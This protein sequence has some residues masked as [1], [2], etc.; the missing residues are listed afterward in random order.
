MEDKVDQLDGEAALRCE[1]FFCISR[2]IKSIALAL[3]F[4]LESELYTTMFTLFPYFHNSNLTFV[5]K[6]CCVI[7]DKFD[8]DKVTSHHEE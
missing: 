4:K 3:P 6:F 2:F 5:M 1:L 7:L 8:T